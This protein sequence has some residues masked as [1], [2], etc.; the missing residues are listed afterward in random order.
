MSVMFLLGFGCI[1][2]LGT[3]YHA[4]SGVVGVC[5]DDAV[6]GGVVASCVHGIR[7]GL[8]KGGLGV[9]RN[10]R[11]VSRAMTYREPHVPRGEASDFDHGEG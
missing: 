1:W 7:S 6:G 5:V 11:L 4:V 2:E 3:T 8:V 10:A 9:V